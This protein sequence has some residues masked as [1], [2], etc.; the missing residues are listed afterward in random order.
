LVATIAPQDAFKSNEFIIVKVES[1]L[2]ATQLSVTND[3]SDFPMLVSRLCPSTLTRRSY[4]RQHFCRDCRGGRPRKRSRV[5][6]R[7][8]IAASLFPKGQPFLKKQAPTQL[9]SRASSYGFK[10]PKDA[11]ASGVLKPKEPTSVS[12][13]TTIVRQLVFTRL[14]AMV[15]PGQYVKVLVVFEIASVGQARQEHILIRERG[16]LELAITMGKS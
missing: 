12:S 14:S 15:R 9:P 16:D 7:T 6:T 3:Y 1:T 13:A 5:V 10:K 8:H 2:T 4:L 11:K